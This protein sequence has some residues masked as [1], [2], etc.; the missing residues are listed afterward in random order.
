MKK[1]YGTIGCEV[2]LP[3]YAV[4]KQGR[5]SIGWGTDPNGEVEYLP[6]A[7]ITVGKNNI[8]LYAIWSKNT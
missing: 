6:G 7:S 1:L 3:F 2:K 8:R 4:D 5:Q